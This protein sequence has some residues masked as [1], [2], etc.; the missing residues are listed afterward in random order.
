MSMIKHPHAFPQLA[1]RQSFD[2]SSTVKT[3]RPIGQ[4]IASRNRA[5]VVLLTFALFAAVFAAIIALRVAV[6]LPA[7]QH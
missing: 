5:Y 6:W 3:V 1:K 4:G 2:R 7:F